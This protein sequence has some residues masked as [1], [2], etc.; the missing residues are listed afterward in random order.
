MKREY[1]KRAV[2]LIHEK[3]GKREDFDSIYAASCF[4]GTSFS[5]VQGA[6][7]YNGVVKDWKVYESPESIRLHIRDLEEQ[8]RI[9]N[10]TK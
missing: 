3:T 2:V 10:T 6:A 8:L 7:L 5:N 1:N 9:L 4:L